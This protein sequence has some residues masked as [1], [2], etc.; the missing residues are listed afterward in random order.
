MNFSDLILGIILSWAKNHFVLFAEG[1]LYEIDEP[2]LPPGF[3][4][5]A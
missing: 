2:D 3:M 4:A 1:I 5:R